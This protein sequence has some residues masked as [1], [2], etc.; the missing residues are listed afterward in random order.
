M[1]RDDGVSIR[2]RARMKS[3]TVSLA[4]QDSRTTKSIGIY[5]FSVRFARELFE[6]DEC[7]ELS[8]LVNDFNRPELPQEEKPGRRVVVRN[9][10][11]RGRLGRIY[12]DQL[13]LAAE[14]RRL[15]SDWL[16]LPKGFAPIF[17]STPGR[18]L[19]YI[20]DI[21]GDY[22]RSH[23]PGFESSLE[24]NYFDWSLQSSLRRAHTVFTNTEFSRGEIMD[25]AKRKGI[26]PPR[27]VPIGYGFD[28]PPASVSEIPK[29]EQVIFF[30]SRVPHK[31]TGM[32]IELLNAWLQRS[33]FKG[34]VACVGILDDSVPR[35][36]HPAFRWIGRVP[37]DELEGM[38]QRAAVVVYASE[39]EG[40][41]MPPV[42]AVQAGTCP[43]Y[44]DIP[45]LR[46]VMDGAGHCFTNGSVDSFYGA[47]ERALATQGATISEWAKGL[48]KRYNWEDV[49]RRFFDALKD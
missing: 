1:Q 21:M 45:P 49:R 47:M 31:K 18:L 9:L 38:L 24:F 10:P 23:Y 37:R 27:V 29:E 28:S 44:S 11:N 3:L 30:A 46:E 36:E 5:N 35:P 4:D 12:W 33:S 39:Y 43:V 26:A 34:T 17:T 20:H 14:A 8:V 13:R 32:A 48:R 6:G 2:R 7:E 25:Y 16:F 22:Y 40:F 41:G 42:E 15:G 19:V